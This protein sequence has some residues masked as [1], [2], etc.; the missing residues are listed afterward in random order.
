MVKRQAC[1]DGA[2]GARG[3]HELRS[4]VEPATAFD[5]NAYTI[6]STYSGGTG[7]GVLNMYTTHVAPS[8]N[9][10]HPIEYRMTQLNGWAVTG[11]LETFRQGATALRNARDWA[12]EK[13]EEIIA[14][15]NATTL[16]AGL[17]MS[18]Q[19]TQSMLSY[20]MAVKQLGPE[21]IKMLVL[22]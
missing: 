16:N 1:Y 7:G 6:T 10:E 8:M 5:N 13:R 9:A 12:K 22:R 4:Y 15:A 20:P 2:L 18:Q 17:S 3:M 19:S 21:S 14:A 11:N